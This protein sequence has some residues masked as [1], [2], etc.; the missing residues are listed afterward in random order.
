M[1]KQISTIAK[2]Y[3]NGII[4]YSAGDIKKAESILFNLQ[5]IQNYLMQSND[6]REVLNNPSIAFQKKIEIINTIFQSELNEQE[7]NILK[8]LIDKQRFNEFENIIEALKLKIQEL[9]NEIE[10]VIT[11]AIELDM[12]EKF[13][14]TSILEKKLQKKILPTWNINSEILGGLFIQIHNDIIDMSILNK[15]TSLSKNIIR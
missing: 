11:S 13:R 2:T 12:D 8:I 1:N 4:D 3:A 14:I 9:K 15:I 10:V 7:I 6:L 5:N